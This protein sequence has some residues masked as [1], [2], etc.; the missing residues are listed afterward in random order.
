M[1]IIQ[2]GLA[3]IFR[4]DV[5][6]ATPAQRDATYLLESSSER[7]RHLSQNEKHFTYFPTEP[8]DH[9]EQTEIHRITNNRSKI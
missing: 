7:N 5:P 9:E 4:F 2:H 3:P 6:T 8:T 1:R